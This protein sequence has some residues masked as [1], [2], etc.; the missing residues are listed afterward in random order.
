M[1]A[2]K[3]LAP[4]PGQVRGCM[5]GVSRSF[6]MSEKRLDPLNVVVYHPY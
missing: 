5:G 1:P 4:L 2:D 3:A 6:A